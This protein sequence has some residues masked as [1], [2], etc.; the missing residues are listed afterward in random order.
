MST[1]V[2]SQGDDGGGLREGLV[3]GETTKE[4]GTLT[5]L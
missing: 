1:E 5:D 2:Q 4:G 3:D